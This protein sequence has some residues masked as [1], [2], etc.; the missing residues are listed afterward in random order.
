[1]SSATASCVRHSRTSA[2][3][4][5]SQSRVRFHGHLDKRGVARMMQAA[6]V[7]V[8]PSLWENLPCVLLEAMSTGL[9]VVAT[10]VGGTDEIVDQSSGEL[11]EPDSEEALVDGI[12][13]VVQARGAV[14]SRRDASDMA[15]N[16]YGYE[17]VARAWTEIYDLATSDQETRAARRR[18]GLRA[19]SAMRRK[20][21]SRARGGRGRAS[22]TERHQSRRVRAN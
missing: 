18:R 10:R 20:Q 13:R 22:R 14:R 21:L 19:C 5:A 16:R 1:M 12:M 17:A 6:D 7:L 8:L 9:P 15:T 2:R 4:A 11:V 3:D